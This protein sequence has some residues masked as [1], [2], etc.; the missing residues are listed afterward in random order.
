[1]NFVDQTRQDLMSSQ[2]YLHS[3]PF[4]VP[5]YLVGPPAYSLSSGSLSIDDFETIDL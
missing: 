3:V 4:E 1:V 5:F 2:T